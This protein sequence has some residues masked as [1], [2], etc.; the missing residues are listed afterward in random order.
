M[1]RPQGEGPFPTVKNYPGS[2]EAILLASRIRPGKLRR[3]QFP[4]NIYVYSCISACVVTLLALPM[5]NK[6]CR[7]SG[8]ID[9][10]GHRKI[11]DETIPLSG[12]LA[13]FTGCIL[14]L[15]VAGILVWQQSGG[16]GFNETLM[17]PTN[18]TKPQAAPALFDSHSAFLLRHGFDVRAVRLAG[19][20]L[21]AVG[22]L[23]VGLL[24]DRIELK[25][26]LKFGGQLA[27]A[28]IV[29]ACGVRI[30]LFV[31]NPL[32]HYAITALWFLTVIN[33]FNF[34]DNMNGLCSG[35]GAIGAAVFCAI[36]AR[37]GQYLVAVIAF[38]ALGALL[39]FLPYNYPRAKAFL[40][41]SGSHLVGYL[42]AVLSI[43]PHFYSAKRP[44]PFAVLVPLFALA[45]PLGDMAYV[46]WLRWRIGQPFYVGD[47]NH[48]SHRL[49]RK[50]FSK[51]AAV[52]II[53]GMAFLCGCVALAL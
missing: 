41:D 47:N 5:W 23:L 17:R 16:R 15:I 6:L 36:A 19:I 48:L 27:V 31:H 28:L 24:D 4:W 26:A 14:P 37:E 8:L 40:G 45:I 53:W 1:L 44:H 12:G 22:I 25:P 10:P 30:T 3:V 2:Y 43:L 11:H 32:F 13:V 35:L 34:M 7:A 42:L 18:D 38:L 29:A 33:A 52:G 49:V 39:G 51:S 21:G 50:G 9:E 20:V 46:V